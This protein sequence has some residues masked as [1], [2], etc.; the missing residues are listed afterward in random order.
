MN[1][2]PEQIQGNWNELMRV[3]ETNISSP[4]KEKLKAF[5][6]IPNIKN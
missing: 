1:L 3:I 6:V 2:T 5:L 4:R